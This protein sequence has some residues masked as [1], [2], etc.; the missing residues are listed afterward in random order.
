MNS[1]AVRKGT[2]RDLAAWFG[3]IRR[4]GMDDAPHKEIAAY[5]HDEQNVPFWWAQEITVEYEKSIGRRIVGQTHDGSFQIGASKTVGVA[6]DAAWE[7][8]ESPR[9]MGAILGEVPSGARW[10]SLDTDLGDRTHVQTTT[11]V[12]G[13]HVR[14]RWQPQGDEAHSILQI[15]VTPKDDGRT[16][17]SF[18]HEKLADIE[19]REKLK[20]RWQGTLSAIAAVIE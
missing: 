6:A 10:K 3:L 12:E 11:Y 13:S 16:T 20:Q 19:T 1:N 8:I 2:G 4:G 15:R 18:H 7:F 17:L 5:L 14:L 9:G